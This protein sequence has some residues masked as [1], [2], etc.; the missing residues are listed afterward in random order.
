MTSDDLVLT[1]EQNWAARSHRE[2]YDA[3]HQNNDPGKTGEIGWHWERF[4]AGLSE[5]AEAIDKGITATEAG[6]TGVSAE[7]ARAAIRKLAQWVTETAQHT[8]E[9]GARV[10]EQSRIMAAARAAM[11]EPADFSWDAATGTLSGP[12]IASFA[13]SAADVQAA[14]ERARAAHEQAVAVMTEME[15]QSK[16]VDA[17]T[18]HFTAP[19]NPTTG[20]VE[21]V[22][23]ATTLRAEGTQLPGAADTPQEGAAAPDGYSTRSIPDSAPSSD[24][25]QQVLAASAGVPRGPETLGPPPEP[26]APGQGHGQGGSVAAAAAAAAGVGVGAGAAA[27]RGGRRQSDEDLT[28]RSGPVVPGDFP[29]LPDTSVGA[30]AGK[31]SSDAATQRPGGQVPLAPAA[32]P[33]GPGVPGGHGFGGFGGGTGGGGGGFGGLRGRAPGKQRDGDIELRPGASTGVTDFTSSPAQTGPN[34]SGVVGAHTA[35]EG[36]AGMPPGGMARSGGGEDTER[37]TAYVQSED[38]FDVPGDELPPS[39]IGG[40]KKDPS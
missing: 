34:T 27:A 8:S 38:L 37:K 29:D 11:P 23:T 6:W 14:N 10:Q 22:A 19:F 9:L 28:R 39:V 36:G 20:R 21:E 5:S 2:L 18:P 40:R 4:G 32:G 35:A 33:G 7:A 12:G 15:R 1:A 25:T 17:T 24:V 30:A 31:Q 26:V 13:A 3:V 16:G